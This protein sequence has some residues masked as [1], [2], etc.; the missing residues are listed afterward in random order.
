M[1]QTRI[2]RRHRPRMQESFRMS[3]SVLWRRFLWLF[4]QP[5][6]LFLT[7][8]AH[9]FLVIA[10]LIFYWIESPQNDQV[11]TVVDSAYWVISTVTTVGYGNIHSISQAGKV[12]SIVVMIGG[13]VLFWLYTALFASALVAPELKSFEGEIRELEKG[14]E[15]IERTLK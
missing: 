14:I 13:Q 11:K 9:L 1:D 12:L 5:I 4:K 6:F 10:T 3:S 15:D 8:V 7:V 2:A